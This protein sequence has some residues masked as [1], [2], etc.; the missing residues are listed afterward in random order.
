MIEGTMVLASNQF[1]A[2]LNAAR[3]AGGFGAIQ[4]ALFG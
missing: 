3:G 2:L 4:L 1:A